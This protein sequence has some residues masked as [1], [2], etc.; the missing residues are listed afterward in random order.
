MFDFKGKLLQS[1]KLDCTSLWAFDV[2][3]SEKHLVASSWVNRE[4]QRLSVVQIDQKGSWMEMVDFWSIRQKHS[5]YDV[6]MKLDIEGFPI[7][8]AA[9]LHE[10]FAVFCFG[11][12]EKKKELMALR[13]ID[14]G[15]E[16]AVEVVSCRE[17]GSKLVT[18]G[19]N[20]QIHV[21]EFKI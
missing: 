6:N 7:V 1:I 13:K 15:Y 10:P 20:G 17:G 2:S 3:P 21:L 16:M 4:E 9:P 12:D 19:W 5:F 11:F 18:G 8:S 14:V